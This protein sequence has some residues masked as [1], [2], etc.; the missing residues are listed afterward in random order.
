MSCAH[1]RRSSAFLG[2]FSGALAVAL[3]AHTARPALYMAR[4][5]IGAYMRQSSAFLGI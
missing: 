4:D 2:I 3:A 1:M 5:G